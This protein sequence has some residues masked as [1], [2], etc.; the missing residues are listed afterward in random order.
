MGG[1]LE[2]ENQAW[3]FQP[4]S[5]CDLSLGTRIALEKVSET[6]D[7]KGTKASRNKG[8]LSDKRSNNSK[9][10]NYKDSQFCFNCKD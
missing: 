10:I 2:K 4:K 8:L 5:L 7:L 6:N 1:S 3:L 9:D